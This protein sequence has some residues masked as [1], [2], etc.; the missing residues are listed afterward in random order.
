MKICR[1][2]LHYT[3]GQAEVEVYFPDGDVACIN[4]RFCQYEQGAD[5]YFCRLMP[6]RPQIFTPRLCIEGFC[7]L[8]F[9]EEDLYAEDYSESLQTQGERWRGSKNQ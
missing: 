4:C 7:P 6:N 9:E 8:R 5:R 3:V 1:G 2:T